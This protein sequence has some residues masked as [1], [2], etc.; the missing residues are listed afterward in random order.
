MPRPNIHHLLWVL[1]HHPESIDT[2]RS[3]DW[4]S[5]LILACS[6]PTKLLPSERVCFASRLLQ[7]RPDAIN[8]KDTEGETALHA[9]VSMMPKTIYRLVKLLLQ[10]GPE[11]AR[12]VSDANYLPLHLAVMGVASPAV[13]QLLVVHY[14]EGVGVCDGTGT[15]ALEYAESRAE[16]PSDR[17]R[18][19]LTEGG[20]WNNPEAISTLSV[21]EPDQDHVLCAR[22]IQKCFRAFNTRL[23][24]SKPDHEGL[25]RLKLKPRP[26][27]TPMAHILGMNTSSRSTIS[28]SSNEKGMTGAQK[29]GTGVSS[30]KTESA[31]DIQKL[32]RGKAVRQQLKAGSIFIVTIQRC[33]RGYRSRAMMSKSVHGYKVRRMNSFRQLRKA[34]VDRSRSGEAGSMDFRM[35]LCS[36]DGDGEPHTF[37]HAQTKFAAK[38]V[39]PL[40]NKAL[41][42]KKNK[43]WGRALLVAVVLAVLAVLAGY[44][45]QQEES[46][47]S[48]FTE[49]IRNML[50]A[51]SGVHM[52]DQE[53]AMQEV[54][55]QEAARQ[56]AARQEVAK[57]EAARQEAAMQEVARQEA[58]KQE[59]ARQEV[60]SQE[61]A[62][63]EAAKQDAARQEA[64]R[65]EAARQEV[66]RQEAAR[67]EV[68]KQ[69]AARNKDALD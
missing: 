17:T 8:A 3:S 18:A 44:S 64:A 49:S 10:H 66:A 59:A 2:K 20:I 12:V 26:Q 52:A 57:Q 4:A 46:V 6:S 32:W 63:Q 24:A 29:R 37:P 47:L 62:R 31:T 14:P 51:A 55:S 67:Q 41:Q 21:N 58:A 34:G 48:R 65:Q 68:A 45:L 40:P 22:L 23:K 19:I 56:E 54:A 28:T 69:E 16:R 38:M 9:A 35:E 42:Q 25:N 61:A 13:L 30:W 50:P 43:R 53:A 1:N 7:L 11:V 5:P 36:E 33:W 60:A 27:H 39:V 15:T